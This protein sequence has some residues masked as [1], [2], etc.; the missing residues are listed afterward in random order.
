MSATGHG[1][2]AVLACLLSCS[3]ACNKE[4]LIPNTRVPDTTINRELINVVE[5][6]RREMER[7][8]AA[9][10]LTLIHPGYDDNGGTP[11]AQDDLDYDRIKGL[12]ATKFKNATR[13]R[14]RIDYR[15]VETKGRE[16][17]I[18]AWI[19]A[20]FVYKLADAMPRYQRFADHNRFR[21]LKEEGRWRFTS[22][23]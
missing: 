3:S 1:S 8:N 15:R 7:L 21:L 20:S 11:D 10:V 4:K 2:I 16:A 23:L 5:R 18:D 19:D 6:Y 12:L 17:T 9:G 22:G 13:V 14:F